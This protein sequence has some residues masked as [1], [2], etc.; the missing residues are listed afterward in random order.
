MG[1]SG[2]IGVDGNVG[3]SGDVGVEGFMMNSCCFLVAVI[4]RF[5]PFRTR[6][7]TQ[8]LNPSSDRIRLPI[9]SPSVNTTAKPTLS[10]TFARKARSEMVS[11][12]LKRQISSVEGT[13]T[14]MIIIP[15]TGS[16]RRESAAA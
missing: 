6:P 5:F 15:S 16:Q 14:L 3:E 13:E 9:A 1:E 10:S 2:V 7:A 4:G 11:E 12:T 8:R